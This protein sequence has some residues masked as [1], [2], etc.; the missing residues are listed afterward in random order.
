LP[1]S[2]DKNN[3]NSIF[4]DLLDNLIN[5]DPSDN[6]SH[7]DLIS[8]S[9]A[10]ST[11][12]KNGKNLDVKEMEYIVNGLFACKEPNISPSNKRTYITLTKDDLDN[13]FN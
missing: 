7:S 4:R 10:K 13:K 9:L 12:I 5:E 3:L 2:I 6:F 1:E 11:S 8:K